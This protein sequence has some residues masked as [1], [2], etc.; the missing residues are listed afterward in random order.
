ML[1]PGR[2][3]MHERGGCMCQRVGDA[4]PGEAEDGD[5]SVG[6]RFCPESGTAHGECPDAG[7]GSRHV[8]ASA[9]SAKEK[10]ASRNGTLSVSPFFVCPQVLPT[11][12][13]THDAIRKNQDVIFISPSFS[14]HSGK[15]I[16]L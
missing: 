14:L 13:S 1:S 2:D 5:E 4:V 15:C 9:G 3:Y 10:A 16:T 8:T 11:A 6:E 7:K 12:L